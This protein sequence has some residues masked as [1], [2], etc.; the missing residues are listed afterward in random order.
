MTSDDKETE[1]FPRIFE[2]PPDE[3]ISPKQRIKEKASE[4]LPLLDSFQAVYAEKS[5]AINDKILEVRN[6]NK[7]EEERIE[8]LYSLFYGYS[9]DEFSGYSR[10]KFSGYSRDD[11]KL[12]M[13]EE[14][15]HSLIT[16]GI[17]E[18][19]GVL[20][21]LSGDGKKNNRNIGFHY[22]HSMVTSDLDILAHVCK[23]EYLIRFISEYGFK[24]NNAIA[25]KQK[26]LIENLAEGL[27]DIYNLMYKPPNLTPPRLKYI[28]GDHRGRGA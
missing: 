11:T 18:T 3:I 21:F 23:N 9:R 2:E 25:E 20:L 19:R 27:V 7:T 10:G 24:N 17:D 22:R 28:N 13:N 14:M 15:I 6:F 16:K 26:Q 5:A 8:I 12:S 4:L 1:K